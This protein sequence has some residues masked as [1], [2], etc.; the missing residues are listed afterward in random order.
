MLAS[1]NVWREK[2]WFYFCSSRNA[3]DIECCP[4]LRYLRRRPGALD[5]KP[6]QHRRETSQ[7][8]AI[9]ST[10]DAHAPIQRWTLRHSHPRKGKERKASTNH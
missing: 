2:S 9:Q 8:M 4:M 5:P 6:P 10:T 7:S 1:D 3:E